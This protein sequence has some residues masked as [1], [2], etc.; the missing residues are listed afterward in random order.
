MQP[1]EILDAFKVFAAIGVGIEVAAAG[2]AHI[3]RNFT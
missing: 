3:I 1:R 2:V